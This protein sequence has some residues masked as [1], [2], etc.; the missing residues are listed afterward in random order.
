MPLFTCSADH[1]I[2][3]VELTSKESCRTKLT[4]YRI[5]MQ[6]IALVIAVAIMGIAQLLSPTVWPA[7]YAFPFGAAINSVLSLVAVLVSAT[8]Q[9]TFPD[10]ATCS[11]PSELTSCFS[12]HRFVHLY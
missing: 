3:S 7:S 8:A 1:S 10:L 9:A 11:A 4:E 2:A 5:T 6:F 12:M